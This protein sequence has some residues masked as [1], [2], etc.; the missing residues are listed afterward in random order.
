LIKRIYIDGYKSFRDFNLELRPLSVVFGPNANGKSNLLDAVQL[1]GK[2]ATSPT[3]QKAFEDHRGLPF[4]SFNCGDKGFDS[5]MKKERLQMTFEVDV[6]LSEATIKHVTTAIKEKRQGLESSHSSFIS[7]KLL[8]YRLVIEGLPKVGYLRVK[9]ER[10]SALRRNSSVEKSSRKAF[11]ETEKQ[12]ITLRLEGQAHPTKHQIGLDHTI[13]SKALYEPHYPHIAALKYELDLWRTYYFS[14]DRMRVAEPV[15]EE[16]A[17]KRDG[18]NLMAFLNVIK[19]KDPRTFDNI[20]RTIKSF[21]PQKPTIDIEVHGGMAEM[22]IMESGTPFPSSLISEGT[23]RVIGLISVLSQ[24]NEATLIAFEEP[25]NGIH[26]I[27]LKQ[28]ADMIQDSLLTPS[29]DVA[30]QIILT[31]HSPIFPE[32]FDN[33]AL[34]ICQRKD[35]STRIVPFSSLGSL[36]RRGE[37]GRALEDRILSGDFGG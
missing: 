19:D 13:V 32:F 21:L 23:L 35:G 30:C 37:I 16:K 12:D 24:H 33:E 11:I 18:S 27:R 2:F 20:R 6:L 28:I 22:N 10:L 25:E 4:Q 29:G 36:Y 14:P 7:E 26:P 3:L 9:E 31:S 1:V 5:L 8:R 15:A 17:I 34:F